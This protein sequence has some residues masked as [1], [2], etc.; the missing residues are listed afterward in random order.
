L[1]ALDAGADFSGLVEELRRVVRAGVL[2]LECVA[3]QKVLATLPRRA[4][5]ERA[6]FLM[7]Q[8]CRHRRTQFGVG[9]F[10]ECASL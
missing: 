7:R 4:I 1:H 5:E 3:I 10:Q 6:V 2:R 8:H 9:P